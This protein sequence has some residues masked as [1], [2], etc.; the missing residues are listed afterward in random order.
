MLTKLLNLE[1]LFVSLD[2]FGNHNPEQLLK[3]LDIFKKIICGGCSYSI[4]FAVEVSFTS[5]LNSVVG[6]GRVG[7]I[8]PQNFGGLK[9]KR[10]GSKF[11]WG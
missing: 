5:L 1:M 9:T 6:M 7:H 11:W 2:N 3:I 10:Q 4:V 8:G